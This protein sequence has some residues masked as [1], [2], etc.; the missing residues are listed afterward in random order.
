MARKQPKR[1]QPKLPTAPAEGVPPPN[2]AAGG[3]DAVVDWRRVLIFCLFAF[4]IAG[5]AAGYLALNGGL[6]GG[7]P[8][9]VLVV[10]SAW[11]MPA[12]AWANLLTRLVTRE[13]WQD[14]WLQPHLR[15]AWPAW[16]IAWLGIPL[17]VLVGTAL[18]FLIFPSQFDRDYTQV[19]TLLSQAAETTGQAVPF[20]PALFVVIQTAQAL[21]IAP[22]INA[23]PTLG[24]EFGW[25]AY[26]QQKLMP[27]G[28]RRAM[29][30]MGLIWGAWHWP[31]IALGY[32]FGQEYPGAPWTGMLVFAWF[33]FGLGT[34]LGWLTLRGRSVWPAVIGHGAFNGIANLPTLLVV[35]TPYM[36]LG[37]YAFGLIGSIPLMLVALWLWWRGPGGVAT[38]VR[39]RVSI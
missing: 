37:P 34:I 5:S 31:I 28:W 36:L 2:V 22:L 12:P 27:L 29:L 9:T 35:G 24:E 19:Q 11:Y 14:L 21:L 20:G 10:L 8:G 33:T 1:R 6:Q 30:L 25:R 38:P 15:V 13:G 4:A 7:Q 16:L 3:D 23:L 18:Y 39:S 17:L 32:N 26:L